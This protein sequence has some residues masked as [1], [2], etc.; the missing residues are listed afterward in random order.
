MKANLI[1]FYPKLSPVY[2]QSYQTVVFH[3]YSILCISVQNPS[4]K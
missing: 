2:L 3:T 1:L 4:V